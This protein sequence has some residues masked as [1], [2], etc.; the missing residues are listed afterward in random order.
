[1]HSDEDRPPIPEPI[2]RAVRQRYRFGCAACGSPVFDYDHVK[3]F[4]DVR[5]HELDN[6]ILLCPNHHS[7]KTRRRLSSKR[8][9][10][11]KEHP[12][13]ANRSFSSTYDLDKSDEVE[14]EVGSNRLYWSPLTPDAECHVIWISGED[15]FVLHREDG[16]ITFSMLVTTETGEI[17]LH[18]DHGQMRVASDVWDYEYVGSRLRIREGL[19][20]VILDLDVANDKVILHAA[21]FV[22]G[23]LGWRVENG[24]MYSIGTK[25]AMASI[26]GTAHVSGSDGGMYGLTNEAIFRAVRRPS[27]AWHQGANQPQNGYI[28]FSQESFELFKQGEI[29]L[30]SLEQL[31]LEQA[32][33]SELPEELRAKVQ[34]HYYVELTTNER[35][36]GPADSIGLVVPDI[37]ALFSIVAAATPN[38][39][40]ARAEAVAYVPQ[41]ALPQH[42]AS[43]YGIFVEP[44]NKARERSLRLVVHVPDHGR[45]RLPVKTDGILHLLGNTGSSP[46]G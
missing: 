21:C 5:V 14:I 40:E 8:L 13:N 33:P 31:W 3:A 25:G 30:R 35:L 18:V 41:E 29:R 45:Q 11:F 4:A 10:Y 38:L 46:A 12:F 19:R 42:R 6:L 28:W 26:G 34:G 44:D 15:H 17:I 24:W 39:I 16:W 2:K 27:F 32:P 37:R 1:M 43:Q 22:S 20:K 7:A 9:E 23:G 36:N